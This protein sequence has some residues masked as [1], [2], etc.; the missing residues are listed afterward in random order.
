MLMIFFDSV[1]FEL[2]LEG[3]FLAMIQRYKNLIWFYSQHEQGST[4]LAA[5]FVF[6]VKKLT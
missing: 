3:L 5:F 4:S 6:C 2:N 1:F